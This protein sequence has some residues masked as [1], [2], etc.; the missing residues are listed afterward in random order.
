MGTISPFVGG[1]TDRKLHSGAKSRPALSLG[2]FAVAALAVLGLASAAQAATVTHQSTGPATSIPDNAFT[3]SLGAGNVASSTISVDFSHPD[4][5]DH[6]SVEVAIDHDYVGDLT[7]ILEAP[8]NSLVTLLERPGGAPLHGVGLGSS[9]NLSADQPITF[10]DQADSG[11][12]AYTMGA[13]LG[14]SEDVGTAGTPDNFIPASLT[15]IGGLESFVGSRLTG[16]WTLHVGDSAPGNAGT[17]DH[18]SISAK[19]VPSPGAATAGLT[20]MLGLLGAGLV[21]RPRHQRAVA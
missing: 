3:G 13:E 19:T 18:W 10:D 11:R 20:L 9:A 5:I 1:G 8:D 4:I 15:G 17:L 12:I 21:R 2:L 16:D 14:N 6:L 7:I